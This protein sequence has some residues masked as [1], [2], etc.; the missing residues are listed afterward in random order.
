VQATH[1]TRFR[2]RP[3]DEV[4]VELKTVKVKQIVFKFCLRVF[5]K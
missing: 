3:G 5:E 1:G 2:E 4:D